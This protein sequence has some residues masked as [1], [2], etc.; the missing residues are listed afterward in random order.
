MNEEM[1]PGSLE[2]EIASLRL[3]AEAAGFHAVSASL[4]QLDASM[5]DKRDE[6]LFQASTASK[7]NLFDLEVVAAKL[8]EFAQIDQKPK[9]GKPP[10]PK[11]NLCPQKQRFETEAEAVKVMKKW[12]DRVARSGRGNAPTRVYK[13]EHCGGGWHLTRQ[14]K[15]VPPRV[16]GV[17]VGEYW[18]YPRDG[19][20]QMIDSKLRMHPFAANELRT[21]DPHELL[22]LMLRSVTARAGWMMKKSLTRIDRMGRG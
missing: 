5:R 17:K 11:G 2:Y 18:N 4:D 10:A 22:D 7:G 3:R 8:I 1:M 16:E 12:Q 20:P 14:E 9:V 21:S 13:C 19:E 15:R 6:V